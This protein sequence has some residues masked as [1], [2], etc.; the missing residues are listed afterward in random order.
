MQT[1]SYHWGEHLREG[2]AASS[3]SEVAKH[4]WAGLQSA[5]I[6]PSLGLYCRIAGKYGVLGVSR[7]SF[8]V[9]P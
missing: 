2:G 4:N 7:G 6:T 3:N 1:V 9:Y 5:Q 8:G